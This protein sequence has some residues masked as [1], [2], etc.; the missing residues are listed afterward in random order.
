MVIKILKN[1]TTFN[2]IDYSDKKEKKGQGSLL[3]A[4]NFPIP[5]LTPVEH[6][7]Y[8]TKIA[9]LNPNVTNKQFHVSISANGKDTSFKTLEKVAHQYLDYMGYQDNPY[10]IYAHKDTENNHIHIVST[11]VSPEG[12]KISDSLERA[13]TQTF[14]KK[15]LHIDFSKNISEELSESLS[16]TFKSIDA[17]RDILG[18]KGYKIRKVKDRIEVIKSGRVQH[19]LDGRKIRSKLFNNRFDFKKANQIKA[20]IHKYSKGSDLAQLSKVL[21]KKFGY[22]LI[23]NYTSKDIGPNALNFKNAIKGYTLIDHKNKTA[24]RHTD[25]VQIHTLTQNFG[26]SVDSHDLQK[27]IEAIAKEPTTLLETISFFSSIGYTLER[28]GTLKTETGSTAAVLPK[29]L[30]NT[31]LYNQRI[32][33]VTNAQYSPYITKEL[34]AHLYRIHIKDVPYTPKSLPPSTLLT[35]TQLANHLINDDTYTNPNLSIYHIKGHSILVDRKKAIVVDLLQ[36]LQ[37]TQVAKTHIIRQ[38]K[39]EAPQHTPTDYPKEH[40][41]ILTPMLNAMLQQE[42]TSDDLVNKKK[43]KKKR[44]NSI[45][46]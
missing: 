8:M 22:Q 11:R 15:E 12:E 1:A 38:S 36:D 29:A 24:Y 30:I 7:K 34:L 2:G 43:K 17:F 32:A 16:Y 44:S 14:I 41:G 37:L 25:L 3:A 46:Y 45:N 42:D 19:T 31:L 27:E 21:H 10:L 4:K 20:H 18:I 13:R 28:N 5:N 23:P 6:E 35:Y 9:G 26:A 40:Q 39:Q 33:D